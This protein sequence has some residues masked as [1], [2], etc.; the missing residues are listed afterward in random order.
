MFVVTPDG[1]VLLLNSLLTQWYP[2]YHLY[3]NDYTPSSASTVGDFV[4]ASWPDYE[5]RLVRTFTPSMWGGA[6]AVSFADPQRWVRGG[7]GSPAMVYGYY[8][9]NG[10]AGPL[11]LAERRAFGPITMTSATDVA[12]VLPSISFGLGSC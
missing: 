9:T 2:W 6:S 8:V 4:E 5:S 7:G 3:V 1:F 10:L 11:V 12:L